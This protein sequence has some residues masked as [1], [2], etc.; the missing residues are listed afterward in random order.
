MFASAVTHQWPLRD[1]SLIALGNKNA[2][3]RRIVG[4]LIDL[5]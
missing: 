4:H 2:G 3:G 5:L 1:Q